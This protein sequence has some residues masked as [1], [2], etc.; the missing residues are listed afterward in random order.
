VILLI[1]ESCITK[2][3]DPV[4]SSSSGKIGDGSE[5]RNE[6][7][8]GRDNVPFV[9]GMPGFRSAPPTCSIVW[10]DSGQLRYALRAASKT[11]SRVTPLKIMLILT[12]VALHTAAFSSIR[13]RSAGKSKTEMPVTAIPGFR[14]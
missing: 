10:V 13:Y 7:P 14:E 2:M 6:G 5:E 4:Q 1:G 3:T 9:N 11:I 12:S 8:Q